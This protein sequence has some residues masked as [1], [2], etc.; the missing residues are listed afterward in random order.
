MPQ[1]SAPDAPKPKP[2]APD[3]EA[4]A[5]KTPSVAKPA[6]ARPPWVAMGLV[7]TGLAVSMAGYLYTVDAE[8]TLLREQT[9]ANFDALEVAVGRANLLVAAGWTISTTGVLLWRVER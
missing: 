9:V 4:S 6:T 8:R 3:A 2:R 5:S 7:G 1:P